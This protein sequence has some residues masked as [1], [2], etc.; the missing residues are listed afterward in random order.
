MRNSNIIIDGIKLSDLDWKDDDCSCRGCRIGNRSAVLNTK[1]PPAHHSTAAFSHFG[2]EVDTDLCT[3]FKP[4]FP[5]SFRSMCNFVDRYGKES[6]LMF[7]RNETSAE[8]ASA[9]T[10]FHTSVQ[11]RLRDGMIGRWV[12]DNGYGFMGSDVQSVADELVRNRG[13]SVPNESNTLAVPER[14]W[15][16]LQRMMRS[17]MHYPP[18]P[19]PP[20]M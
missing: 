19:V 17:D 7:M 12:T 8:T 16:V 3:G 4:S 1:K 2:Q 18:Q 20:C 13:Y 10:T 5:H 11:H 15:G 14:H 6:W 9:L